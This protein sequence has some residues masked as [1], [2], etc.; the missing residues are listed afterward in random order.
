M[1]IA[2]YAHLMEHLSNSL[3]ISTYIIRDS[4]REEDAHGT[5]LARYINPGKACLLSRKST[6]DHSDLSLKATRAAFRVKFD[7]SFWFRYRSLDTET[8]ERYLKH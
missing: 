6:L 7:Q 3:A 5:L 1:A 8:Q 4:L 2:A